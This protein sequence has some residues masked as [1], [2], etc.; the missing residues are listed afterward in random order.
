MIEKYRSSGVN[1]HA[2][3]KLTPAKAIVFLGAFNA[4]NRNR[5]RRYTASVID[6]HVV[7]QRFAKADE[8]YCRSDAH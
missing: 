2:L 1:N 3:Q 4:H 8:I 5:P 7:T 6:R